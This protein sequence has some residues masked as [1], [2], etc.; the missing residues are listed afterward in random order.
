[1]AAVHT[2]WKTQSHLY[3]RRTHQPEEYR[4]GPVISRGMLT[5]QN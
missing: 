3:I 1:M 4:T 5:V 2:F